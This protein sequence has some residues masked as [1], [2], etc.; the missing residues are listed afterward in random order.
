MYKSKTVE[1]KHNPNRFTA[2]K[3]R[4]SRETN[5]QLGSDC[6]SISFRGEP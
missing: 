5:D 2:K 1:I 4:V 6:F 3:M